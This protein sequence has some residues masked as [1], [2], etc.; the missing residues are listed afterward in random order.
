MENE[1]FYR[2]QF[3]CV[4][5]R[6]LNSVR[7]FI[8]STFSDTTDERNGLIECVYPRLYKYCRTKYNIQFQI[9]WNDENNRTKYFSQFFEDF[10]HAITSQIDFHMKTY[11]NQQKNFLY[12]QILEHAIQCNLLIQRYFPRQDILEQVKFFD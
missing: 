8:S 11:E 7:V 9:Q 1:Q 3:D 10:Y 2:G 4:E 5:D 12:N 6:K